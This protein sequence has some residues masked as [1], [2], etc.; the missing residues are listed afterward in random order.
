MEYEKMENGKRV[1]WSLFDSESAA[2]LRF[3]SNPN[4]DVYCFGVGSGSRHIHLDLSSFEGAF[5]VLSKCPKPDYIFASPP[6]ESW[7]LVSVGSKRHFT[8]EHGLNLYW[9]SKWVPFDFTVVHKE[10]RLNGVRTAE[11]VARIIRRFKP[12]FWAVE[13]GARSLL[14]SFLREKLDLIGYRNLTNYFSY[15]FEYL[16]PTIIYSNILLSLAN[17]SPR[18]R[19]AKIVTHVKGM[20]RRDLYAYR[21]RVPVGLYED[22]LA[23]FETYDVSCF[24]PEVKNGGRK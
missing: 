22:I 3:G 2:M 13:N 9:R 6:C 17:W 21:S 5:R 7:C 20:S 23:Q 11:T 8:S 24:F 4:F 18:C 12:E 14:F 15:G 19:L 16:K 1:I 10:R